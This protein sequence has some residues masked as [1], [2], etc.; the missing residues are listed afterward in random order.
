M[1]SERVQKRRHRR[2]RIRRTKQII[3][4]TLLTICLIALLAIGSNAILT[5]ATTTDEA[6]NV[7]YKYY[8]QLEIQDGDSLW[9]IA[10]QYMKNGPYTSRKEYMDE[11]VQINQLS[12]TV[13][14]KGQH[15]II[16]YFEDVY[17]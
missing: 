5:K 6:K 1:R 2:E 11:V 4:R 14:L 9:S 12:D 8:T 17:K 7:Y 3:E 13:I 16:P 10:G 15:L